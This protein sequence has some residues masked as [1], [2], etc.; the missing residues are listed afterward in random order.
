[1]LPHEPAPV[2]NYFAIT[3]FRDKNCKELVLLLIH[4]LEY[5]KICEC[6]KSR[7]VYVRKN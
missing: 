5:R 7:R 1:M 3:L 6:C 2:D 4:F